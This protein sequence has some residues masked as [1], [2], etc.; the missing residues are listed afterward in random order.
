MRTNVLSALS[1]C[2]LLSVSA[3][4]QHSTTTTEQ[5][6]RRQA[7]TQKIEKSKTELKEIGQDVKEKAKVVGEVVSTEAQKAAEAIERKAE[8]RKTKRGTARRDTL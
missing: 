7:R 1:F 3:Y 5:E 2:L 8:E 4:A 6:A